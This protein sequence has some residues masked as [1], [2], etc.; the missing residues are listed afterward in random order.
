MKFKN[1]ILKAIT[2]LSLFFQTMLCN[3]QA[4]C[5]QSLF[6]DDG[7]AAAATIASLSATYQ[8]WFFV[9]LIVSALCY[10]FFK[11]EKAKGYARNVLIGSIVVYILSLSGVQAAVEATLKTVGRWI[12]AN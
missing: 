6:E 9:I 12:G 10:Y 5:A 4:T 3:I 7:A 2:S 11:D 1:R 8:K